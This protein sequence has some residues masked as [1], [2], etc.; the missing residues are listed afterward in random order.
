MKINM[1]N[2]DRVLRVSI[3]GIIAALYFTGVL[4]GALGIALLVLAAVFVVSSALGV[5]P[6]YAL[7][8][9]GTRRC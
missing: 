6:I 9:N 1:A 5:C 2:W 3:A 8:S 4:S 7:L